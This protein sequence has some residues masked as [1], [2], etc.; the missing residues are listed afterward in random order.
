MKEKR[1]IESQETAWP[2]LTATEARIFEL[3]Q[4]YLQVRENERHTRNSLEFA[5]GL[6]DNYGAPRSVVVPALILHDVGWS[7][8]TKEM[9][10][11]GWGPHP[12]M[13]LLAL[14]EKEGARIASNI[15]EEIG[16]DPAMTREITAIID[17]HDTRTSS[18]SLNDRVVKDADKLTRYGGG[19][20][21]MVREL[22]I[23]GK[24]L[25]ARLERMVDQ[26]FFLDLSRD[27]A[28][29]ELGRRRLEEK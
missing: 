11:R 20:W 16:Y 19:F 10:S 8:L 21:F 17:G 25:V 27:I 26:W 14:H 1:E 9:I 18:L 24:D 12:D 22:S 6:L 23:P 29:A 7:R 13:G 2:L 28:R 4:P 15:L 5:A 3:A